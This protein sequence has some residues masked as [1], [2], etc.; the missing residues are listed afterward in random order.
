M[1][2]DTQTN[3]FYA[4]GGGQ[5]STQPTYSWNPSE[6]YDTP[7]EYTGGLDAGPFVFGG[8]RYAN[9]SELAGSGANVHYWFDQAGT[10]QFSA[11]H[12]NQYMTP[13]AYDQSMENYQLMQQAAARQ[14]NEQR[15]QDILGGFQSLWG[16]IPQQYAGAEQAAQGQFQGFYDPML[17]QYQQRAAQGGADYWTRAAQGIAGYDERTQRVLDAYRGMESDIG[18]RYGQRSADLAQRYAD[19]TS[20]FM[21]LA[22][23]LGDASRNRLEQQYAN[24][25]AA[26]RQALTSKGMASTSALTGEMQNVQ[27][28]REMAMMDLDEELARERMGYGMQLT[29]DEL[30]ALERIGGQEL[31]QL[32]KMQQARI[33]AQGQLSQ[34]ALRAQAMLTGEA[35]EGSAALTQDSLAFQNQ[36]G[37]T[38][39]ARRQASEYQQIQEQNRIAQETLGFAERRVDPYA[40][41]GRILDYLQ[42]GGQLGA[43]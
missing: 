20:S 43:L 11:W 39:L 17:Q 1:A 40:D 29:G 13:G 33:G 41:I 6:W 30:A 22:G 28:N 24:L 10:P 14:Q 31:S 27:R 19:R 23:G 9:V 42:A 12:E 18:G 37:G 8:Q 5:G 36:W 7:P 34:E 38:E 35:I 15:Y 21:G 32:A 26:K 25:D 4:P 2:E 3:P 16:G